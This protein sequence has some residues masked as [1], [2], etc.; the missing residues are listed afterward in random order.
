MSNTRTSY[1]THIKFLAR[2]RLLTPAVSASIPRSNLHRWKSEAPDKYEHFD[3]CAAS[4]YDTLRAFARDSNARRVFVAYVRIVKMLVAIA[5][6]MPGFHRSVKINSKQIVNVIGRVRVVVGLRRALRFF[7]VSVATYRNWSQQS[8]AACFESLTGQCNRV[9]PNQLSRPEVMKLK[10]MMTDTRFQYWPV[11]SVAYHAL[12]HNILPLSLNT[13][14]KYVNKL[15]LSRPIPP[16]RRKKQCV[17]VRAEMP[18]QLWHADV[19]VFTTLDNIRHYVYLL[20]DNFSRKVLAWRMADTL[21]VQFHQEI[22]TEALTAVNT[23]RPITLITDGGH[24]NKLS[25]FLHASGANINQQVALV[26]VHFS[27][28]LIEAHH[29]VIKYNYLFRQHIPDGPALCRALTAAVDDYN[30]RPHISLKGLTPNEAEQLTILN[31]D[32]LRERKMQATAQRR[33][34]NQTHRCN[35]C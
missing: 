5:H 29:K 13:W 26:D 8:Y 14:Y 6:G 9:F 4:D 10:S 22:I 23:Q 19:T 3:L 28:S 16:S 24:E 7:N 34:Y 21:K 20:A 31:I 11:S 17:S 25:D 27:N 30:N 15:G 33:L 2:E 18:H 1:H 35:Q 32:E 12:R